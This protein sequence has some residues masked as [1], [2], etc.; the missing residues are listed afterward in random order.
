MGSEK[1]YGSVTIPDSVTAIGKEA[2]Q[3]YG[4]P[5]PLLVM[6]GSFAEQYAKENEIL[7]AYA[8]GMIE[9]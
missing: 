5:I 9:E 7:F 8:G 6:K 2:F 3:R 4:R 1:I